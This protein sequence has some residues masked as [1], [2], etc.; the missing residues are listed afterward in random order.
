MPDR[1]R[2]GPCLAVLFILA[3]A[4]PHLR[5][6]APTTTET[7]FFEKEVRPL[8][9]E[10]CARCHGDKAPKGGLKLTARAH[11]LQGGDR[12]PALAPGKPDDSLLI[13]AIRY[14][15]TPRMPPRGKL[16]ARQIGVLER[17][18]KL[19]A[20][21]P[22][23]PPPPA[24]V[25]EAGRFTITEEQRRFWAFQ[26]VRPVSLPAVRHAVRLQSP[27]DNFI[28]SGLEARG[29]TPAAPADRAALL[30]RVTFD[31]IGLPPTPEEITAFLEDTSPDAYARVIDRLLASPR[32]GEHWGRHWLDLVRYADARD[33]IQLP[34]ASDFRE[35][36]HYRDWVVESFNR[37]LP[38]SDFIRHQLA[39]DLLP[40]SSPGGLNKD[41]II[42]T[43]M[44]ALADFVPGDVDKDQMIAD[45]V[46]DQIDVVSRAFLGLTVACARCHD[47][48]FDPITTED[49]YSLAGIFFSTR[50][51][52][53]PVPGNTPLIKVPLAS[54]AE[55]AQ[56]AA[57]RKRK[58]ELERQIPQAVHRE[59]RALV[60]RLVAGETARYLAAACAYRQQEKGA[61]RASLSEVAK[62]HRIEE[63]LLAGW[64]AFLARVEKQPDRH[65]P[66][67]REAAAGKLAGTALEQAAGQ[68]QAAL[69]SRLEAETKAPEKTDPAGGLL[70]RFRADDPNLLTDPAGRVTVLPNH[71]G[72][73][74]D[75]KPPTAIPGPVKVNTAI[76]GRSRTVLRF[77]DNTLLE[78]PGRAPASGSLFVV[79]QPAATGKP[80]ARLI[81]W[82]DA[83]VGKHGLGV[84][85]EPDGRLHAILRR[86]GQVGDLADPGRITG[87]QTVSIT[88]GPKGT[89]LHRNG[90][91][92]SGPGTAITGISSDPAIGALRIGGPGSGS[93]PRFAGDVAELRI[94][95]RQLSESERQQVEKE[96]HAVWFEGSAKEAARDPLG[97]LSKELLSPRGPFGVP[98]DE[99][100]RLLSPE[101]K[102]TLAK[103]RDEL[104]RLRRK[105]ALV[106]I[107]AVSVQDGGP[108]GTRHEGFKDASVFLRGDPKRTG[109]TV[110]RGFP[111]ILTG[112]RRVPITKGSGRRE[113][114]DWLTDPKN[115]LTARVMVNRI[116]QHHFGEG[117]VRTPNDFGFRGERPTHPE[118]LD[119]LTARFVE[120]GWSVKAVHR[121]ILLSSTYQQGSRVDAAVVARDPENRLLGRMN[122]RRLEAEAIRDSLQAVAGE[123]DETPGGPA[124]AD[125]AR[126]RRTLYLLSART[127]ANTSDFGTLFDRADPGS[128]VG[129]RGESVGAPQALFFLNDPFVSDLARALGRR[130]TRE[131]PAGDE[132]RIRRLY[133]LVLGRPPTRAETALGVKL[134]TRTG[135]GGW[136]RYCHLILCANEF[137]YLD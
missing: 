79:F 36:W 54:E 40:P 98:A 85:I 134:L 57:D 37:D 51:I 128:I 48:K 61:G 105:P 41:G 83:S 38:Y 97:D 112:D 129:R 124:F 131:A 2:L 91:A 7:E 52:P 116:W 34:P 18:V 26:P 69:A 6:A 88:W 108:K 44:L 121:L 115:P 113:L 1:Q 73:L 63:C 92:P 28:L 53:G 135:T 32:Y 100:V 93:S 9:V 122:R 10:Q 15:N 49:Y 74:A 50:L 59:Y 125:L 12:G 25:A 114:A 127:G 84:M 109:K 60:R 30:R 45:Y 78:A 68:L 103:S 82:E 87:F 20:P 81:G 23:S 17:W 14:E 19:G 31:L 71:P 43:G 11:L 66:S 42:A 56:D 70:Y 22:G 104:E 95:D 58:A 75:G 24:P 118:L 65:P 29:L 130:L 90:A 86:D 4:A 62:K 126:P 133:L 3:N 47:H 67:L 5:G 72:A 33:L 111:L 102:A 136:E 16:S 46:N 76:N 117:L 123:L 64:V 13:Q 80:G 132:A 106:P 55:L 94:Y 27:I 35:I 21:W 89:T 137:I 120:S 101:V 96:L 107:Q 119:Y 110:P 77:D 8:L 39:G 99:Q